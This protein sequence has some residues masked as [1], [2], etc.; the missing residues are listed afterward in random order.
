MSPR[1]ARRPGSAGPSRNTLVA[2]LLGATHVGF[3]WPCGETRARRGDATRQGAEAAR[4][5]GAAERRAAGRH[6][7]IKGIALG[8]HSDISSELLEKKIAEIQSLGASHISVVVSWSSKDVRSRRL[9]PRPGSTPT[10]K[11]LGHMIDRA[12]AAKLAVL[13]FPIIDIRERKPFEWRG[14]IR[15]GDWGAWWGEYSQ[16][17]LHYARIAAK[18][19]V[20][21]LA[22]GS[23]LVS[24][25]HMRDRWAELIRN[26]RAIYRGQLLY[27]ANWDHYK[28]VR[29]WD[30]VDVVG[31][32]AYYRLTDDRNA[33]A[34]QM[35]ER[36][37]TIRDELVSWSRSVGR[38]LVFTE[39]GY[40][41]LDGGAVDPWDYTQRTK[42]DPE[43]QY[44]AYVAFTRAWTRVPELRG[45]FFWDWY[46]EGGPQNK[47]Y[48]PRGK[49]AETVIRR[50][51][52]AISGDASPARARR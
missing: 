15:P 4:A 10:D 12:R 25:E 3:F 24:T 50:W 43:E 34:A 19:D 14:T 5:A 2:L 20:E 11:K 8:H 6:G 48:T 26:V 29:F 17:I 35:L 37:T 46:G 45:V 40:P 27:S 18:H 23:E 47:H 7:L 49:P 13:V 38:P 22:V 36:W 31:L 9:A 39:V 51:F 44:R 33:T 41:S 42:A 52:G 1:K 32:T 28:P 21:M 16:F 30:L